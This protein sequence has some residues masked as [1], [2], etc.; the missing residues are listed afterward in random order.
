MHISR[1]PLPPVGLK[2]LGLGGEDRLSGAAASR[3]RGELDYKD[4]SD[5]DPRKQLPENDSS[6]SFP[7][8]C[9]SI[10]QTQRE[11]KE[12]GSLLLS[13]YCLVS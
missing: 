2:G 12:Q 3:K 7:F 1:A 4:T 10:D 9:V 13:P 8:A 6:L 5:R 11:D